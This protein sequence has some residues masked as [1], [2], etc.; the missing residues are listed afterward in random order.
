MY[1]EFRDGLRRRQRAAVPEARFLNPVLLNHN[2]VGNGPAHEDVG[3]WLACWLAGV[4]AGCGVG[5][6]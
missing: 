3:S 4:V 5:V 1:E 2:F 6:C